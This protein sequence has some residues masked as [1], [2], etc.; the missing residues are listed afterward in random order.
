MEGTGRAGEGRQAPGR[1]CTHRLAA[2]AWGEGAACG[3]SVPAPQHGHAERPARVTEKPTEDAWG[4]RGVR[5]QHPQAPSSR[6]RAVVC[7][8]LCLWALERWALLRDH[9]ALD[10]GL[11]HPAL[12][13][14]SLPA[15]PRFGGLPGPLQRRD[16]TPARSSPKVGRGD[17]GEEV[18]RSVCPSRHTEAHRALRSGEAVQARPVLHVQLQEPPPLPP[19]PPEPT[20]LTLPPRPSLPSWRSL[21]LAAGARAAGKVPWPSFSQRV[22][23][24]RGHKSP[25]LEGAFVRA[26]KGERFRSNLTS[27]Q[28]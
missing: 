21:E 15:C 1:P 12:A 16:P 19:L 20:F 10:L 13:R 22:E 7:A 24:Q 5:F 17:V 11:R 8:S 26:F 2:L 6:G 3:P 25:R 14:R 18:L 27:C 4:F 9:A 23:S 28:R